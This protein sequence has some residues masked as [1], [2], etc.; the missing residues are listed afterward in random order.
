MISSHDV[1]WLPVRPR[2]RPRSSAISSVATHT[3]YAELGERVAMLSNAFAQMGVRAGDRIAYLGPTT[4]QALE[5]FYASLALQVS[6]VPLDPSMSPAMITTVADDTSMIAVVVDPS[7]H[8]HIALLSRRQ[9]VLTSGDIPDALCEPLDYEAFIATG[10]AGGSRRNPL[11][12]DPGVLMPAHPTGAAPV[13]YDHAAVAHNLAGVAS[14][15]HLSDRDTVLLATAAHVHPWSGWLG[16]ATLSR[17]GHVVISE[18]T[19]A[20]EILDDLVDSGAAVTA[21][22]AEVLRL[23]TACVRWAAPGW[24]G[25]RRIL[26]VDPP[27]EHLVRAWRDRGT[28]LVDVTSGMPSSSPTTEAPLTGVAC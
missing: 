5:S 11:P 9:I 18:A 7:H 12:G 1:P 25:P 17:G 26:C 28:E 13:S 3:T 21:L 22:R 15:L 14:M 27:D 2:G 10:T 24:V 4:Q 6:H 16:A 19:S 23:M 20:A 8:D